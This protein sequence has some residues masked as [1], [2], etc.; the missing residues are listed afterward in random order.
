M[1]KVDGGALDGFR[2]YALN[3]SAP[4]SRSRSWAPHARKPPDARRRSR[5]SWTPED[6]DKSRERIPGDDSVRSLFV[7]KARALSWGTTK[8]YRG[9]Q[10]AF[11]SGCKQR[12][13]RASVHGHSA[14]DPRAIARNYTTY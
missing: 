3:L 12:I 10:H 9:H 7:A 2:K 13:T 14:P 1:A 5:P 6:P 11:L 4:A 8:Q